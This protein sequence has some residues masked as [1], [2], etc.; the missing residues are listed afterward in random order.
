MT[1]RVTTCGTPSENNGRPVNLGDEH[2][3]VNEKPDQNNR[4]NQINKRYPLLL[5]PRRCFVRWSRRFTMPLPYPAD[6][7]LI[8]IER[9]RCPK[10]QAPMMLA[11]IEHGP[12][13]SDLLTFE[14]PKCEHVQKV[15]TEDQSNRKRLPG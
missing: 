13:V 3:D 8:P 15:L 9:P 1:L 2:L 11:R 5:K 7:S 4:E 6:P 12:A 10:C 14:C